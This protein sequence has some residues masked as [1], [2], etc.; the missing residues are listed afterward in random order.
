MPSGWWAP[1]MGNTTRVE[2]HGTFRWLIG[3]IVA[4]VL[5][6]VGA[7][8]RR[9][10]NAQQ[11]A[12]CPIALRACTSSQSVALQKCEQVQSLALQECK[13]GAESGL[14]ACRTASKRIQTRIYQLYKSAGAP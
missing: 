13:Q 4:L 2:A 12:E 9:E 6:I 7:D 8:G 11:V 5:I 10:Y 1:D 14:E 3:G